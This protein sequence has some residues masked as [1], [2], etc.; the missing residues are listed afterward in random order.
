MT[1]ALPDAIVLTNKIFASID[2]AFSGLPSRIDVL[3][4]D[5]S[6]DS[7]ES[8]DVSDEQSA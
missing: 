1:S 6:A 5:V 3:Y 7:S 2:G 4:L 8:D